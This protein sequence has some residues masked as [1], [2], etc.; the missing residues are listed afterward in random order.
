MSLTN[1]AVIHEPRQRCARGWCRNERC[2]VGLGLA[3][4]LLFG[5]VL[6]INQAAAD[7]VRLKSGAEMRGSIVKPAES[8]RPAASAD[9]APQTDA[10]LVIETLSG[11]TVEVDSAA[12]AFVIRR[13][14]AV[15]EY[16]VR[17][18]HLPSTAEDHWQMAQWC[19]DQRLKEQFEEHCELVVQFDP[20]HQ[21][22]R[23]ALGHVFR[24]GDWVDLEQYMT[25][26]GYVKHK[27]RWITQQEWELIDKTAAEL[28][29]EQ[30]WATKVRGWTAWITGNNASR[31][32]KG[33]ASLLGIDDQ[34]AAP[35]IAKVMGK[36]AVRDVRLLGVQILSQIP[37]SKSAMALSQFALNDIDQEIRK[38]ARNAIPEAD[39][40][41]VQPIFLK[42]LRSKDNG[43]VN[44]AAYV[45]RRIGNAEAI[46]PLINALV[47]THQ[48]Q[49]RVNGNAPTITMG[50][51][52]SFGGGTLPPDLEMAMRAGQFPNGVIV[53][54]SPVAQMASQLSWRVVT[55]SHDH[56][57][58]EALAALQELTGTDY[59]YDERTWHLWW[60]SQ[61]HQNA[62]PKS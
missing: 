36:H 14:A 33:M 40:A 57:N 56:Q 37:G 58:S 46:T 22:A 32:E 45:L 61:N 29:R 41:S 21:E 7:V 51:D 8:S 43:E 20:D 5:P 54:P 4:L 34:D 24:D 12:V 59:G 10:P 47:T 2:T 11:L 30:E 60:A 48:Y 13:P 9:S 6:T 39:F 31:Q 23:R 55:I 25:D 53:R 16:E 50:A 26:R 42:A 1:P 28:A 19:R 52:G 62:L 44:R 15:E 38:A 35:G 49:V 17:V 3:A 18:R 27:N